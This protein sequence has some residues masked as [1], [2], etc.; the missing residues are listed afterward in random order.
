MD[1]TLT[2]YLIPERLYLPPA[3]EG[4]AAGRRGLLPL[5]LLQLSQAQLVDAQAQKDE[6]L[7]FDL[8]GPRPSLPADVPVSTSTILSQMSGLHATCY[9]QLVHF[10]LSQGI[11]LHPEDFRLGLEVCQS[12]SLMVDATPLLAAHCGHALSHFT[13]RPDHTPSPPP[14]TSELLCLLLSASLS[15]RNWTCSLAAAAN[16]PPTE[17]EGKGEESPCASCTHQVNETF[18]QHLTELGF[19][20]VTQC[21]PTHFWLDKDAQL[22]AAESFLVSQLCRFCLIEGLVLV[23]TRG[24]CVLYTC[25]CRP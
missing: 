1:D 18:K 12:A 20:E 3:E 11:P 5:L 21:S 7:H 23:L 15:K 2:I 24:P 22:T 25:V 14:L 6:Y 10:A 8:V 17:E 19:R 16:E 13:S 4:V 9:L